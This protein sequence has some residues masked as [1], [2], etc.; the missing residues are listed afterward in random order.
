MTGGNQERE[1]RQD[2]RRR[3]PVIGILVV[4]AI[5]L[6]LWA[7]RGRLGLGGSPDAAAW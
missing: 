2:V 3:G 4:V 5:L 7:A 1:V 6:G